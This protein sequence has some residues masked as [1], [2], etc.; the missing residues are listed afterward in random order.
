MLSEGASTCFEAWGKEQK[1]NTSLCHPWASAPIILFIEDVIGLRAVRPG[2]EEYDVQSHLP[3]HIDK[4]ML[5]IKT[6]RGTIQIECC[7]NGVSC[8]DD[9]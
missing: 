5:K 6:V 9:F 2:F 7:R 1:W 8:T 4:L 3:Q